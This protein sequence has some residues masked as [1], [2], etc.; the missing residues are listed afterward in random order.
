MAARPKFHRP[1]KQSDAWHERQKRRRAEVSRL[2]QHMEGERKRR[3]AAKAA[4]TR[5]IRKQLQENSHAD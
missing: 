1:T 5:R 2:R 4:A 3:Q